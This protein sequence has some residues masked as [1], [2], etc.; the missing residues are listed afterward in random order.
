MKYLNINGS[1][2]IIFA[3]KVRCIDMKPWIELLPTSFKLP[4]IF[5]YDYH[6]FRS[7]ESMKAFADNL[8]LVTRLV[9][10]SFS[11]LFSGFYVSN[12]KWAIALRS[13]STPEAIW[14]GF[15]TFTPSARLCIVVSCLALCIYIELRSNNKLTNKKYTSSL[16]GEKNIEYN[17]NAIENAKNIMGTAYLFGVKPTTTLLLDNLNRLHTIIAEKL[18]ASSMHNNDSYYDSLLE[19]FSELVLCFNNVYQ[20]KTYKESSLKSIDI[21]Y[22]QVVDRYNQ[23]HLDN[24]SID[25][26]NEFRE[27]LES[28][29]EQMLNLIT[30]A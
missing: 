9:I 4:N 14:Q 21:R 16:K 7:S 2:V 17:A 22:N 13:L 28:T 25:N 8:S 10:Y 27:V 24:L 23:E 29:K 11:I 30:L 6:V 5:K 19:K 18:R 1:L 15:I 12:S 26:K 20:V 3:Y